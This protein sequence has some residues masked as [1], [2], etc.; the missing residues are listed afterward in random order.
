MYFKDVKTKV[1]FNIIICFLST[2]VIGGCAS[3]DNTV[4]Y[5][6]WGDQLAFAQKSIN[7]LADDAMLVNMSARSVYDP[8][9]YDQ[10]QAL[11]LSFLFIR[12]SG[13]QFNVSFNTMQP[14][15]TVTT[16]DRG[17]RDSVPSLRE[18]E[19]LRMALD[20]VHIGP[21]DAL[22]STL[23]IGRDFKNEYGVIGL[24]I[25]YLTLDPPEPERFQIPALWRV[26]YFAPVRR[27]TL[28]VWVHPQ[29]GKVLAQ[30]LVP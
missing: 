29:T 27:V 14:D 18:Q 15:K 6:Y 2:S 3:K 5:I 20:S 11:K 23:S 8:I 10:H 9:E 26:T 30:D 1:I 16:E 22:S 12:P 19:Y 4:P 24:P 21:S 13:E 28:H 17:Q 25:T 7:K